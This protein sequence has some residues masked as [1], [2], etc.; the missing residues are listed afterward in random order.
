[1]CQIST[2]EARVSSQI[3]DRSGTQQPAQ[4]SSQTVDQSGI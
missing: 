2:V 1:L 3:A 4:A